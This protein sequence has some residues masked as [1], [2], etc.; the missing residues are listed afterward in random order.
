MCEDIIWKAEYPASR[1]LVFEYSNIDYQ[2]LY[3]EVQD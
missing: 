1:N 2:R 3:G